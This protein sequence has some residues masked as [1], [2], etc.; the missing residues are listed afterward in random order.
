MEKA[1]HYNY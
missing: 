1:H